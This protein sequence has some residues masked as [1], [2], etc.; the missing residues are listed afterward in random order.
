[1]GGQV[2]GEARDA[3][4][5]WS[6]AAAAGLL[7]AGCFRLHAERVTLRLDARDLEQMAHKMAQSLT[8]CAAL[9]PNPIVVLNRIRNETNQV[10]RGQVYLI[11]LRTWLTK[12]SQ[13]RMTFVLPRAVWAE[14]RHEERGTLDC[15]ANRKTP[16]FA[17]NG[18]FY[19]HTVENVAGRSDYVLCVFELVHIESGL[20]VWIDAYEVKKAAKRERFD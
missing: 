20:I 5:W 2:R 16:S 12:D 11:R 13:G 18:T 8:A 14:L 17:L 6:V 7:C 10:L 4:A 9:P 1:M 15:G 19:A 3:L